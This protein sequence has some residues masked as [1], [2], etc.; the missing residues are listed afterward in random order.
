MG[1]LQ[2]NPTGEELGDPQ[3]YLHTKQGGQIMMALLILN[4]KVSNR[5]Y[6]VR[7][8]LLDLSGNSVYTHPKKSTHD[9]SPAN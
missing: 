4:L 1:E 2:I 6:S 7:R 8:L 9:R 3:H 5:E